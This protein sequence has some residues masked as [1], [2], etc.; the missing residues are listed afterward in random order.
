M[1]LVEEV[2]DLG[3]CSKVVGR[4]SRRSVG[5]NDIVKLEIP[6][7]IKFCIHDQKI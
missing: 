1:N 3:R 4:Y 5:V 7:L 6:K 2:L